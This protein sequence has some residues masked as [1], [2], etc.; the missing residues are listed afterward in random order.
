M[1]LEQH[2]DQLT[3]ILALARAGSTNRA[4]QA[5]VDAGLEAKTSDPAALTL[6][7]RLLKDRARSAPDPERA[8]LFAASGSAYAAAAAL[9]PNDSYPLINAATVA[10]FA[11]DAERAGELAEQIL[12]LLDNGQDKGETPYW[13]EATRAET[14]L[15]LG[16]DTEAAAALERAIGLAP[17]GYE[18]H[19]T[20]L[21]QFRLILEK[22][23]GDTAWLDQHMPPPAL[24]YSGMIG[25]APGD[26]GGGE[27]IARAVAG[28]NPGFGFGALAA[29]AD[30]F[31]AEELVKRGAELHVILPCPVDDFRAMS[32]APYGKSWE[33]R[34]DIL[35]EAS[36]SLN[37]ISSSRALSKAAIELADEV[38]MGCA[39][40]HASRM[41]S[42]AVSLRI[43]D[44]RG[45]QKYDRWA[46]TARAMTVLPLE[47][48]ADSAV[49]AALADAVCVTYLA[50]QNADDLPQPLG[51]TGR[52]HEQG[53]ALFSFPDLDSALG[54]INIV[55][56][57]GTGDVSAAL[58]CYII[59]AGIDDNTARAR[60]ARMARS[61]A[62]G[63][64][65]AGNAAAMAFLLHR[66]K[67]TAE[68]LGEMA[69]TQGAFTIYALRGI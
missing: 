48:T 16:R 61:A 52:W 46:N 3:A 28:I 38:A 32:V 36:A 37:I 14:L 54:A 56:G 31:I 40:D 9:R 60:T 26:T 34:F 18:D 66:E 33:R 41:E 65:V 45:V 21:R 49:P 69:S 50:V 19:A 7:G 47:R 22:K 68:P 8:G 63:N 20:T 59:S 30:I 1:T 53:T 29:G 35:I 12:A 39:I 58:D 15:L 62:P 13:G 55:R 2:L 17:Y 5:F 6:K 25:I 10:F 11:G 67:A 24:H 57:D 44:A 43:P 27:K 42:K 64:V 51:A 23:S 4:W